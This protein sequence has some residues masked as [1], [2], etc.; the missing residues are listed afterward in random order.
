MR[1]P[2]PRPKRPPLWS[3]VRRRGDGAL[4]EVWATRH[5]WRSKDRE[6]DGL[7]Y[8]RPLVFIGGALFDH[9][10]RRCESPQ[11]A[12]DYVHHAL[13]DEKP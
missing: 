5:T 12:V 1:Q 4:I 6:V 11:A 3:G 7:T 8:Y 10:P 13:K 2:T 9:M